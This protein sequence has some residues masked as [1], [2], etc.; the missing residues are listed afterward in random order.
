LLLTAEIWDSL[1]GT[2]GWPE[3]KRVATD[4]FPDPVPALSG[5]FSDP[6]PTLS[7]YFSDPVPALSGYFSDP[8]IRLCP[9]IFR[10]RGSGFI[11]LFSGS[12]GPALS[13]YFP[14]PGVRLYPI[15]FRIRF[16]LYPVIPDPVRL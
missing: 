11:R 2:L 4:Y 1:P 6:V 15:I 5:N 8:G 9:I 13:D 16:R 7:G 3:G 12:V 10:I 14:D